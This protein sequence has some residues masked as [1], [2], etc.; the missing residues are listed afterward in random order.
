MYEGAALCTPLEQQ[1]MKTFTLVK[2]NKLA[3]QV[4]SVLKQAANLRLN[5]HSVLV[6]SLVAACDDDTEHLETILNV[7]PV[8]ERHS[9]V[10]RWARGMADVSIKCD[11]NVW[12]VT[13]GADASDYD[14]DLMVATPYYS[15]ASDEKKKHDPRGIDSLYRSLER[16]MS[17]KNTDDVSPEAKALA[18]EIIAK[19]DQFKKFI[20]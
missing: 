1:T 8:N 10:V 13:P 16:F 11:D 7:L 9:K 18:F 14:L 2:G 3:R 6:S 12:S 5:L 4:T 19:F 17:P 20:K 15:L